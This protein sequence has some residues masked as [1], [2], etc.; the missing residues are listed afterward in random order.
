LP[1][2]PINLKGRAE[3]KEVLLFCAKTIKQKLK[4]KKVKNIF[5]MLKIKW[6]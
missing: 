1:S 3:N 4:L 5:F 6:K 2:G